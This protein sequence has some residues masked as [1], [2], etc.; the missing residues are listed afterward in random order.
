VQLTLPEEAAPRAHGGQRLV[1]VESQG[2]LDLVLDEK[3]VQEYAVRFN[4]LRSGLSRAAR[5]I[6]GP[7]AYLHAGLPVADAAR[8]LASAG[9]LEPA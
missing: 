8:A 2:T 6:G 7:F 3:A 1:D 4:R 9:V 5:R